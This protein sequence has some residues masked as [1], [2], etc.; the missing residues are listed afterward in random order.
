MKEKDDD[1]LGK[2]PNRRAAQKRS[3]TDDRSPRPKREEDLNDS[4]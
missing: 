4:L 3:F 1:L 2:N